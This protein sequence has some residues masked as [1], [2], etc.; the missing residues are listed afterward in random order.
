MVFV[1]CTFSVL[2]LI[3]MNPVQTQPSCFS[4][5]FFPLLYL[6]LN[7]FILHQIVVSK[8]QFLKADVCCEYTYFWQEVFTIHSPHSSLYSCF[9]D[10][11]HVCVI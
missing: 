4:F 3:F 11:E 9:L 7:S 1:Y 2:G 8:N 6:W 10:R 5:L